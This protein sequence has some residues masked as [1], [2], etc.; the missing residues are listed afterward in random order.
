MNKKDM[1][2]RNS[3]GQCGEVLD[4]L[5]GVALFLPYNSAHEELQLLTDLTQL[6]EID[7]LMM[8]MVI[9]DE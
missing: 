6:V 4:I 1:V 9:N 8:P 3:D 7:G 2:M 5:N